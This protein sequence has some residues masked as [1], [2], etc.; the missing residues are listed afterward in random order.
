M[1]HSAATSQSELTG[2]SEADRNAEV[3]QPGGFAT[4]ATTTGIT[5]ADAPFTSEGWGRQIK[6][7]RGDKDA[8]T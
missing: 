1:G 8:D 6:G 7:G 2:L 5:A 4:K 3:I